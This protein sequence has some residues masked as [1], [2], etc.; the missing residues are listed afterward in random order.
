MD[1]PTPQ[2]PVINLNGTSANSLVE[3][4]KTASH[5]LREAIN[6]VQNITVHGRDFQ[7]AADGLYQKARDEQIARLRKLEEV[8]AELES[9]REQVY[10]QQLARRR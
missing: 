2:A 1:K 7:T 6:A 3:E 4:Y 5:A 9:L 10:E 8:Q